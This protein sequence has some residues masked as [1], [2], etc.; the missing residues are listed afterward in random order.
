MC[1]CAV[2]SKYMQRHTL[3]V[4]LPC[5]FRQYTLSVESL[6][7][8]VASLY[9][10]AEWLLGRGQ[11]VVDLM[12]FIN[13]TD[14]IQ[15]EYDIDNTSRSQLIAVS[16]QQFWKV[17]GV[18]SFL[19]LNSPALCAHWR[20]V[21]RLLSLLSTEEHEMFK[22]LTTDTVSS[23]VEPMFLSTID[24]DDEEKEEDILLGF[25]AYFN[26]ER[27]QHLQCGANYPMKEV[28]DAAPEASPGSEVYLL[29]AVVSYCDPQS[30]PD[31]L[32][33]DASC[34]TAVGVYPSKVEQL[35]Q[36]KLQRLKQLL[37]DDEIYA[38]GE[39]GL[40]FRMAQ[41]QWELQIQA[42]K[43]LL[44]VAVPSKPIIINLW[45][46]S[47][48]LYYHEVSSICFDLARTYL[49]PQQPLCLQN[50][51]GTQMIVDS[52]M[53]HFSNVFF[54]FSLAIV[55]FDENQ[56][57]AVQSLQRS[58]ILLGTSAPDHP[59]DG[60]RLNSPRLLGKVAEVMSNIRFTSK[61]RILQ[62]TKNNALRLYDQM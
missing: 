8:V 5:C 10:L 49:H 25:D 37:W 50:F 58:R 4:H 27:L 43:K 16:R 45:G 20:V 14:L 38:F 33:K 59:P 41:D 18:F 34:L 2:G 42:L 11:T 51:C 29:G 15:W 62:L 44:Q 7:Q 48:D 60:L 22:N 31:P 47:T 6:D 3:D 19:P 57:Q 28:L 23:Q 55:N 24:D 52:W 46:S 61:R 32:P 39:I 13:E 26:F 12:N 21:G 9:T 1:Q 30:W 53:S 17:P 40:D 35:S 54:G 36:E 56:N